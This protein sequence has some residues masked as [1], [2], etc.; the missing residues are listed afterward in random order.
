M[1]TPE[2]Q[3]LLRDTLEDADYQQFRAH[4]RRQLLA[5]YLHRTTSRHPA[6]LL[7]LAACLAMILTLLLLPRPNAPKSSRTKAFAGVIRT[8]PLNSQQRLKTVAFPTLLVTTAIPDSPA[9]S[10]KVPFPIVR[11]TEST[12]NLMYL[13]DQELLA[14]FPGKPVGLVSTSDHTRLLVFVDPDD[15]LAYGYAS[16]TDAIP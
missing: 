12:T 3:Q 5:D 1:N 8:V 2:K 13:T 14:S 16:W 10:S 9:S 6:W 11:T 15:A 4:L 7:A